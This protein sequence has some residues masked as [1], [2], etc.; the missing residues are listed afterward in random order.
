MSRVCTLGLC[1]V[2]YAIV[3]LGYP[4]MSFR[5]AI[6]VTRV[7]LPKLIARPTRIAYMK[8]H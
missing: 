2:H 4:F 1:L 6:I 7:L 5:V 8:V 3:L